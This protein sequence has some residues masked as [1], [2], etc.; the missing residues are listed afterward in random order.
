MAPH[1]APWIWV[2]LLRNAHTYQSTLAP[3]APVA[4]DAKPS[5]VKIGRTTDRTGGYVAAR[6][7]TLARL[8]LRHGGMRRCGPTMCSILYDCHLAFKYSWIALGRNSINTS[9]QHM[10]RCSRLTSS[11]QGSC[12]TI[13]NNRLKRSKQDRLCTCD[14]TL[15]RFRAIIVAVEKQWVLYNLS[16]CICNLSYPACN[17]HAPYCH[18]WPAPL[19]N[20]FLFTFSHK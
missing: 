13:A 12:S 4:F 16:V 14:V 18:L 17:A 2:V 20:V 15:R 19:Y 6:V 3:L 9:E 11:F 1:P 8:V 5:A 10:E 7:S